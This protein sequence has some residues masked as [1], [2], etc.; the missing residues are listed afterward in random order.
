MVNV[1]NP[2]TDSFDSYY[3]K[4]KFTLAWRLCLVFSLAFFVLSFLFIKNDLSE[5][6]IYVL[7]LLVSVGSIIFLNKTKKYL[8][9]YYF[10]A[11]SGTLILLFT[12][13]S[14][15][16]IMHLGDFLWM[17]LIITIAFFGVG[18][19]FGLIILGIHLMNVCYYTLFTVNDNVLHLVPLDFPER[20]ALMVEM[21]AATASIAYVIYQFLSFYNYSY[22]NVAKSN[23]ELNEQNMVIEKQYSEKSVLIKEIHH[24]VKNNLQIIVSLLRLQKNELKSEETKNQFNEAINRIM[25]MSLIHQKLYQDETLADIKLETYLNDL[26]DEILNLSGLSIP[27]EVKVKTGIERIGLK[28]IVPLGLIVNE[29]M[30]NSIEHAFNTNESALISV[31]LKPKENDYFELIYSD[32]GQWRQEKIKTSSFGIE[33]VEALT[34][35]LEGTVKREIGVKQT[36][37]TFQLKN[38]DIEK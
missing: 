28:T 12:A 16:S 30:S 8:F 15:N 33:L 5:L 31:V 37:F 4:G 21:I 25:A 36:V 20:I 23:I 7:C 35:Q 32:N 34:A 27:L 26:K 24:R 2:N 18:K 17:I 6:L 38:L 14:F 11:A 13:N 9:V 1:F 10:I 22:S 29:L 19:K 3:A